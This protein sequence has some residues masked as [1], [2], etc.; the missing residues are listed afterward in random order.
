MKIYSHNK[1]DI[2][3]SNKEDLYQFEIYVGEYVIDDLKEER[4]VEKGRM[5]R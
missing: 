2:H 4:E 5:V 1:R 3:F